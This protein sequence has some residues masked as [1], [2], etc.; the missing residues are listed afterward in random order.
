MDEIS[1]IKKYVP[2]EDQEKAIKKLE[3]GYPL[4]YI[5][6]DVNFYGYK[7]KVNENVL[8]PRFETEYLVEKTLNLISK[9]N[10][11]NPRVLDIGTG[12]GCIAITL[13]KEMPT[14]TVEALDNS[15]KA[16]EVA[17][18]NAKLN[19]ARINF[20]LKDIF[21]DEIT[22]QYDIIISNPP[23]VDYEQKVDPKTAY[24]PQD[25]IFASHHGL[26]F[27]EKI[28]EISQKILSKKGF[29]ALEIGYN[30]KP[31]VIKIFT[32]LFPKAVIYGEK[33]YSGFDRYIFII[34]NSE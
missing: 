3:E 31:E 18:S 6:G 9:L 1:Q 2:K 4:Q 25:A 28:A 19:N 26:I 20:L 21:Q 27:Y 10:L 14:L 32:K 30:Q 23:Y 7:I 15:S 29:I 8:I 13:K 5:I 24:E 34:N 11:D 22:N 33:D 17:S 12:S 16:L